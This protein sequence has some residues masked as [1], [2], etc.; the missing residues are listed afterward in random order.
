MINPTKWSINLSLSE[1]TFKVKHLMIGY[2]KG[3]FNTFDALIY[4]HEKDF[5]TVEINLWIDASSIATNDIRRDEQLK[6]INFFDTK[7]HKLITFRSNDIDKLNA[8]GNHELHGE[9]TIKNI[10]KI[11]TLDLKFERNI[12]DSFGSHKVKF[13]ISGKINRSDYGLNWSTLIEKDSSLLSEEIIISCKIE[14]TNESNMERKI[15]LENTL[16]KEMIL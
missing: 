4:T 13:Y 10:T 7:N 15:E 16:E 11:I 8:T 14:L 2:I 3:G 12:I 1:I 9:L 5:K 6:S